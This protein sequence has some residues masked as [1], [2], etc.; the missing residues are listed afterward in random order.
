MGKNLLYSCTSKFKQTDTKNYESL[1]L[2]FSFCRILFHIPGVQTF[3][4]SR[5]HA[6]NLNK[7]LF[8]ASEAKISTQ[9]SSDKLDNSRYLHGLSCFPSLKWVGKMMVKFI[10]YNKIV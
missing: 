5:S 2:Q 7:N 1:S 8:G 9:M 6:G 4:S 3:L 10:F